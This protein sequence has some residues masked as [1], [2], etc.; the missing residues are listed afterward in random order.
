MKFSILKEDVI[1]GLQK[2]MSITPAKTGAAYLRSLWIKTEADRIVVMSTDASTEFTGS[3]P[4]VVHEAGLI[5]LN[6]KKFCELVRKH[7]GGEILLHTEKDGE[8]CIIEQGRKKYRLPTYD[9][10]WFQNFHDFPEERTVLL[11][12]N[13]LRTLIDRTAFCLLDD[14]SDNEYNCLRLGKD[15]NGWIDVCAM[16]GHQFALFRFQNQDLFNVLS[17]EGM[18]IPKK[19][20]SEIR[21]WTTFDEVELSMTAKRVFLRSADGQEMLSFPLK[22]HTYPD[23]KSFLNRFEGQFTSRMEVNAAD[24][25]DS[26]DRLSVFNT[27]NYSSILMSLSSK[28]LVLTTQGQDVGDAREILEISYSGELDSIAFMNASLMEVITHFDSEALVLEFTGSRSPCR[29][30]GIDTDEN[31]TVISMPVEITTDTYYTEEAETR[32]I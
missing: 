19:A 12:G 2:A 6:A 13:F 27:E 28:A 30:R 5:G 32:E 29:I 18:L 26:L 10:G 7:K 22:L 24:F 31:Y 11:E 21:R 23:Y 3:Y 4:A 8:T 16:N 9:A 20:M 25:F 15:E 17:E 1:E 14:E